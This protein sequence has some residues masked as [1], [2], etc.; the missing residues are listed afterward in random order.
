MVVFSD[1]ELRKSCRAQLRRGMSQALVVSDYTT[2]V[3]HGAKEVSRFLLYFFPT[4]FFGSFL[5]NTVFG[6]FL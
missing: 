5:I 3:L 1:E 6:H 4:Y 2:M